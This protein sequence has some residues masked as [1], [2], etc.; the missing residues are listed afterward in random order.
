[1]APIDWAILVLYVVVAVSIGIALTNRAKRSES[2]LFIA[3]RSLPWYVAGTSMVATTFSADTPLFVAGTVRTE[4][5]FANWIWWAAAPA[6]LATVFFFA[7]LWRRSEVVTEIEFIRIRYDDSKTSSVYRV[8]RAI[9][10]GF[11]GNCIS[12]AVVTLAASKLIAIVLNLSDDP[13]ITL[14]DY[15]VKPITAILFVLGMATVIYTAM[16][17]LFGVVYTDLVQ[18][19]L[20]IVGSFGL[21][22]I[23]YVDLSQGAGFAANVLAAPN[24]TEATLR[25]VPDLSSIN[26]QSVTFVILITVSWIAYAPGNGLFV[27]RI[28]ATRTERDAVLSIYWYALLHFVVRSWPWIIVGL[29]SL[30]Y[31]PV[32]DDPEHAYPKAIEQLLPAG[33]KG[34]MIAS[35]LAAFMSTLDTHMN[36]GASYLVNDV[37]KPYVARNRAPSHYVFAARVCM[38]LLTVVALVITSYLDSILGVFKFLLVM[39]S[40]NAF[41]VI[42]RWYWWRITVWSEIASLLSSLIVGVTLMYQ[43]PD[44][45]GNDLFAVRL[46]INSVVTAL[47]CITTTLFTSRKGPTSQAIAFYEKLRLQGAGWRRV[48]QLTGVEP[49]SASN[50]TNAVAWIMSIALLYSALF[51]VGYLLLGNWVNAVICAAIAFVAATILRGRVGV[52]IASLKS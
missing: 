5:I 25:F 42:A 26:M 39:L 50:W 22:G 18:F 34:I 45:D 31:F 46:L 33:L 24:V 35:L 38:L 37:Y 14:L 20:A 48:R 30:V 27:Q 41:L 16:S 19:G 23:V 8:M 32:L 3:G 6:A 9:N 28:L 43:L 12:M 13:L 29:A 4:G 40:G 2:D 51:G 49:L 15:P 11:I 52:I 47:I 1:M 36:W 44:S 17:G 21:A 7:H 10:D